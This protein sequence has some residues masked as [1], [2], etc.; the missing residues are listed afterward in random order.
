MVRRKRKKESVAVHRSSSSKD[1]VSAVALPV[2]DAWW[3]GEEGQRDDGGR[4]A[5][6]AAPP[7][8]SAFGTV[9]PTLSDV[10][11]DLR[12]SALR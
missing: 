5:A 9:T 6:G 4:S 8:Q 10:Q 7:V 3:T 2:D 1:R 12:T 11:K